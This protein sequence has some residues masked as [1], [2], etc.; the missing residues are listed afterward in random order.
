MTGRLG[1][2][3]DGT[4]AVHVEP[5]MGTMV[6]FHLGTPRPP[7]HALRAACEVLHDVDSR[8]S[9]YR[10]DSE[11]GRLAGGLLAERDLSA[12]VRWVLSACDQLAVASNGA[13]DARRHRA[14]GV[15]DPSAFV[16]GFAVEE[17]SHRLVEADASNWA[18]GAGGDVLVSGA[19]PVDG[20]WRV[21]I[22]HPD[23]EDALVALLE[24]R[25][26]LAVA[27]SG[28]Y[29]R[30][31]HIRDPRTHDVPH[32]LRSLTVVGPSL[33]WAD[34]Y[35]TAAFVMGETG[36]DWVDARPGYGALA[37]TADGSLRWTPVVAPL[38]VDVQGW[39]SAES[40]R[41]GVE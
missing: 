41:P 15:V 20:A 40:H 13:F 24:A 5:V 18:I 16:K 35:A 39:L 30:G 37:V 22:R 4:P 10:P 26:R 38:L 14:D 34:A 9:L 12:D 23:A 29:E 25:G 2:L 33:A 7:R 21:G 17:A 31:D 3:G 36:L 32:G 1:P 6:S 19:G 27:T 28:L 8:F 11:L